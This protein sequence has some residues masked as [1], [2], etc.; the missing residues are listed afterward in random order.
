VPS[1]LELDEHLKP[2][3]KNGFTIIDVSPDK[4]KFQVFAWRPPEELNL[5]DTMKP[6]ATFEVS[7]NS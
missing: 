4:M 2:L 1:H 7:R 5:I 3:E 6:I